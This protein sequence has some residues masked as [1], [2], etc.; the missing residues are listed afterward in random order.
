MACEYFYIGNIIPGNKSQAHDENG[1][2]DDK[3]GISECRALKLFLI[4]NYG[5]PPIN[6]DFEILETDGGEQGLFILCEV[7]DCDCVEY[8]TMITDI[9][10]EDLE[11]SE[12]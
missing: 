6:A 1:V 8:T 3:T 4:D 12:V 7:F 11:E 2:Y 10:S 9:M 5:L